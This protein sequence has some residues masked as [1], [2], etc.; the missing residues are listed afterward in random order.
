MSRRSFGAVFKLVGALSTALIAAGC[1]SVAPQ[2]SPDETASL[3]EELGES[4]T[5]CVAADGTA[6]ANGVLT[7]DATTNTS[8]SVIV[9]P[10]N[11]IVKVNGRTCKTAAGA[12][13]ALTAVKQII[14]NGKAGSTDTF[15]LDFSAGLPKAPLLQASGII[16]NGNETIASTT[17]PDTVV[18]KGSTSADPVSVGLDATNTAEGQV[19]IALTATTKL[20]NIVVKNVGR[21]VV[22]PYQPQ[23]IFSLGTGDDTFTGLGGFPTGSAST[24]MNYGMAIYGGA[25][26]DTLIGGLGSDKI[27]GGGQATDT[28]DY[29]GRTTTAVY[30]DMDSTKVTVWGGDLRG[31]TMANETIKIDK[32]GGSLTTVTFA[33]EATPKDIVAT[34]NSAL[35]AT[36]ATL[37]GNRLR[38]VSTSGNI[39]IDGN[40][41]MAVNKLGLA[42][43]LYSALG[44]DGTPGG[45]MDLPW[46]APTARADSTVYKVGDVAVP[47]AA[48]GFWYRVSVAGT[49]GVGAPTWDTTIGG[50]T[51]ADGGVTWVTAGKVW[52]AATAYKPG[53][54]VYDVAN[55]AIYKIATLT[56]KTGGSGPTLATS[57]NGTVTDGGITWT[58]VGISWAATT[59]FTTGK[60]AIPAT[61]N[62]YYY[63]ATTGGTTGGSAPTWPTTVGATVV[64]GSVTWT[65]MGTAPAIPQSTLLAV[66]T[67]GYDAAGYLAQ[68]TA[69]ALTSGGSIAWP[70]PAADKT[71]NDI[72]WT[73]IGGRA[74][75]DDVQGISVLSGGGVADVLIGNNLANTLNGNAGNDVLMGGPLMTPSA[76]CPVDKLNGGDGND[77][78]DMGPDDAVNPLTQNDCTQVVAGGLGTDVV[79]YSRRTSNGNVLAKLDGTTPSG[80]QTLSPKE[81]D[82]L[83]N[84]IE[85]LL[86]GGG[87]D[88]LIGTDNTDY[89]FGGAGADKIYG[90]KGD[91]HIYGGAGDDKLYGEVG[92]DFFYELTAY[93]AATA[94][95]EPL[96][97][98]TF[99]G[100]G[101][102]IFGAEMPGAGDDTVLG[103]ADMTE[104]NKIDF[105]DAANAVSVALCADA[106]A[107]TTDL[108]SCVSSKS[109]YVA[110]SSDGTSGGGAGTANTYVNVQYL[111]GALTKANTF[112]GTSY[113]EVFEGGKA[114]DI[115]LGQGGQDTLFGYAD[116]A[117]GGA[118]DNSS[119]D[120]LCGGDDDD[121]VYAGTAATIEGEGQMDQAFANSG[122]TS[123]LL[124][125]ASAQAPSYCTNWS[126]STNP[127]MSVEGVNVCF[128]STTKYHCAN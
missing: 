81:A 1:S 37:A 105:T 43:G 114:V 63:K 35:S 83:G 62:G 87:D 30:A 58:T 124:G 61:P 59:A 120:V 19:D 40:N 125:G 79:D 113:A 44:N 20:A 108:K 57:L 98:G 34:I 91:D 122:T 10:G 53:D 4:L 74:E 32:G 127:Y 128:G 64:D 6:W 66:G 18:F 94:W 123:V 55:N 46:K 31:V 73:Y 77:W 27:I 49:S 85:I 68:A 92:N 86:G 95:N 76:N 39:R 14:V 97:G 15:V 9:S 115:M 16:V 42:V 60:L 100:V 54:V 52:K 72:T 26:N 78:F 104:T 106:A 93:P 33:T 80:E 3:M 36:V 88:T 101:L 126:A 25:G 50:T 41:S 116:A 8:G 48:N 11:S 71:D 119:A 24:A 109:L 22:G 99:A 56:G 45:Q 84:D 75:A 111:A 17:T 29:S 70:S 21:S 96:A 112:I 90:G 82:K 67:Y 102:S 13:I 117:A 7:I 89:L 69:S 2:E 121:T 5:S 28:L 110:N 38:L 107:T 65:N 51:A 47:A 118:V 103:G 12:V 23:L